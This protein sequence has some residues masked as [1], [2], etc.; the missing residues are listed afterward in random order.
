M[1]INLEEKIIILY[2]F[3]YN[4]TLKKCYEINNIN[5]KTIKNEDFIIMADSEEKKKRRI[6]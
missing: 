2:D 6:S 1:N 4:N 3:L 5:I